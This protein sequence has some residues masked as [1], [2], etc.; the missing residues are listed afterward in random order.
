M[1]PNFLSYEL[2][3]KYPIFFNT[4]P[5]QHDTRT[6]RTLLQNPPLFAFVVML[7]FAFPNQNKIWLFL[8][9]D[10]SL[11]DASLFVLSWTHQSLKFRS[12]ALTNPPL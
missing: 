4:H 10:G 8:P 11:T 3:E 9:S 6:G 5:R 2:I 7:I 1:L 12:K